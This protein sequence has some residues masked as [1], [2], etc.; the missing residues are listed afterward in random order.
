MHLFSCIG[1]DK[2]C[3]TIS[4][5]VFTSACFLPQL[6]DKV[7]TDTPTVAHDASYALAAQRCSVLLHAIQ[8]ISGLL[9]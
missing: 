6:K 5:A 9:A 4:R 2:T 3:V 8:C 7:V 1:S